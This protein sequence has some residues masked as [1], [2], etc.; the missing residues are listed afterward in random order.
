VL[1]LDTPSIG[2]AGVGTST[3]VSGFVLGTHIIGM[4]EM[5]V[6]AQS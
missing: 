6:D 2:L 5:T 3:A 1:A 4:A